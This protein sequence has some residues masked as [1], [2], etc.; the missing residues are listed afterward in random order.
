MWTST[1][2]S[3]GEEGNLDKAIFKHVN[4]RL[5][6]SVPNPFGQDCNLG[7]NVWTNAKYDRPKGG[8]VSPRD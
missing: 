7:Q 6:T 1:L 8:F 2:F 3:G 5:L 4:C